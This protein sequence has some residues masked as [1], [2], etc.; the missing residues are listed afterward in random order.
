MA[1]LDTH[2]VRV[3]EEGVQSV[4]KKI[5]VTH[6]ERDLMRRLSEDVARVCWRNAA[7]CEAAKYAPARIL[8]MRL[9]VLAHAMAHAFIDLYGDT[10]NMLTFA[11]MFLQSFHEAER[12]GKK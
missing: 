1:Y 8:D 6:E 7:L 9:N 3:T 12:S 10:D 2:L 11:D 5:A 4:V